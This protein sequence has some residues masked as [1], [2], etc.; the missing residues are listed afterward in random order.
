MSLSALFQ[1]YCDGQFQWQTH[2]FKL[3]GGAKNCA[4]RRET[5]KFVGVF[6][7]KNHDFTP[8]NLIFPNFRGHEPGAP[9]PGSAP[10]FYWW[11]TLQY[12]KKTTDLSQVKISSMQLIWTPGK[13]CMS[14]THAD[15]IP[16]I[17]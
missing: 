12:L 10:K 5:R 4:E 11:R 6:R 16:H 13:G 3:G 7:V 9:P 15:H 2:D 17:L 14:T 1:L 8:K